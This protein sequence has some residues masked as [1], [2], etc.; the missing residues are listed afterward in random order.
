MMATYTEATGRV[1]D[2]RTFR[3]ALLKL[4]GLSRGK[5]KYYLPPQ[6]TGQPDK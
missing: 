5:G 1:A 2:E 3:R 4:G 6:P